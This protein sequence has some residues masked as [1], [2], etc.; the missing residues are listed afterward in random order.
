MEAIG[1]FYFKNYIKARWE[2][3]EMKS[4]YEVLPDH[5][6]NKYAIQELKDYKDVLENDEPVV[7]L[8]QLNEST[9]NQNLT[10]L[11][12][13]NLKSIISQNI[14]YGWNYIHYRHILDRAAYGSDTSLYD[15]LNKSWANDDSYWTNWGKEIDNFLQVMKFR[16]DMIIEL[17]K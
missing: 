3:L 14:N 1:D 5:L 8:L 6:M 4:F 11:L 17:K 10:L 12:M 7:H 13:K 15:P 2:R 9:W 16:R